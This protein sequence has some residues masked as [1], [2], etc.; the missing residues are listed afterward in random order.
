RARR[1]RRPIDTGSR[2]FT[3]SFGCLPMRHFYSLTEFAPDQVEHL[4]ERAL[5]FK[6]NPHSD[7]LQRKQIVLL[8][9]DPSLRTRCSFEVAIRELGAG[10]STLESQ[11]LFK[12]ETDLGTRMDQDRAEH[13][14]EATGVLSRY[15]SALGLRSFARGENREDD[16][17]DTTFTTFMSYAKIPVFNMESAVYHPCQA[18]ADLLTI[19]ELFGSVAG[20]KIT[21]A[22]A[23]HP[24]PLPM[25]VPNSILIAST[26]MGMDVTL[27]HPEGFE[28][29]EGIM[30][31]AREF[32]EKSGGGLR[33]STDRREAAQGAEVVYAKSWGALLRY[34]DPE[35]EQALRERHRDWIVDKDLMDLTRR[36][37]FMHCLPVRRNVV[38]SDHVL[39]SKLSVVLR[40]AENRLHAQKAILEWLY[41]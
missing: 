16:L 17:L 22:W 36:A 11:M 35:G 23:S 20:R 26:L 41:S 6:E 27:A 33:V 29:Q 38:V 37:Y 4:L 15:F 13:V 28:L 2:R 19:K 14:K 12:L 24:R 18:L 25:A 34:E 30:K 9:L 1:A 10:V 39:D 3:V 8:F 40:E 7:V 5:Y 31:V 21:I 32:S